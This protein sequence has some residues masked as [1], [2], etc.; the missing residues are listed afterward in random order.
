MPTIWLQHYD[1]LHSALLSP[2]VAG[3]PVVVL[4]GSIALLRMR[5][6]ISALFG[7]GV[8]LGVGLFVYGMPAR[9]AAASALYGAAFG[10]F[11][12]GWIILNVIFCTNSLSSGACLRFCVRV[13]PELHLIRGS[14]SS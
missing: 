14:N 11:P 2:L 6:H 7:L 1:P 13:L 4:L 12:I 3:L 8:A 9:L 10:L 5:I